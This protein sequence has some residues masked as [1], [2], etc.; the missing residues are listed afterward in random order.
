MTEYSVADAKNRLPALLVAVERGEQVTITRY[1]KP[2]AELRAVTVLPKPVTRESL[3]ELRRQL[4]ALPRVG[5][6]NATLID[7]MR[8]EQEP[9]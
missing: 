2:V 3:E 8:D 5:E 6:D 7:R 9:W 1:G 4:A